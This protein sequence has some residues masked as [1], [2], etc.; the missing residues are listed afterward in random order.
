MVFLFNK[1]K[2]GWNLLLLMLTLLLASGC[3]PKKQDVQMSEKARAEMSKAK[4]DAAK[5]AAMSLSVRDR[6]AFPTT[7]KAKKAKTKGPKY[8]FQAKN[9][10]IKDALALFAKANNLNL[11]ADKD[12][13]GKVTVYFHDLT[14]DRAMEAILGSLGYSW[15]FSGNLITVSHLESRNFKIDY[16]RLIR[17]DS[18]NSQATVSSS[19]TGG[20][21][22][23]GGSSSQSGEFKIEK[24]DKIAFWEEL[25]TQLK[26][27]ISDDKDVPGS[28]LNVNTLSGVI[29]VVDTHKRIV[30]ITEYIEQINQSISRQ[31]D[32]EARIVE[33]DL[34][35]DFSLGI[36]W[37]IVA[38]KA[39]GLVV[40]G[41]TSNF[42]TQP[43]GG[44]TP[45]AGNL[46][47]NI[48]RVTNNG[49]WGSILNALKEQ[50]DVRVVSKPH[51]RTMNN[52]AAIIKVGTDR[53]YFSK[54][55]T[56]NST[57]GGAT[58]LSQDVAQVVTEGI[59]LSLTPQISSDHKI[60]LDISPVITR[61]QSVSEVR[62]PATGV[63][64]SSAPNVDVRQS[65]SLVRLVDGDTIILGGLIQDVESESK[66]SVPLLGDIPLL[67]KLFSGTYTTTRKKE[68]VIFITPRIIDNDVADPEELL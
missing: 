20:G 14:L 33:V 35:D 10:N 19:A 58:I 46:N 60:M 3:S 64:T 29:Q 67:G 38:T 36:D 8:S 34:N 50:G 30:A 51:I 59:V 13:K 65:S 9:S 42:I 26:N 61:V 44:F 31:V 7:R 21:G 47:L 43:A 63:V 18:G 32:V 45:A 56:T 62:D 55:V 15:N 22:G 40:A 27:M 39:F 6:L 66:R 12:V 4:A 37:G 28:R 52:Q 11:V 17:S 24:E 68:L 41:T 53:T 49:S 25:T 23:G 16:I 57:A 48:S 2:R 54:Q 5:K 1:E